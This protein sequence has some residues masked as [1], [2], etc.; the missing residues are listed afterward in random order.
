MR[1]LFF[2]LLT[3]AVTLSGTLARAGEPQ[4]K[5]TVSGEA[6]VKVSPDRVVVTLGIETM[7][8]NLEKAKSSNDRILQLAIKA[9]TSCCADLKEI[10][11]A[12]LSIAPR[13]RDSNRRTPEDFLGYFVNNAFAVTL[14]D[15]A[16][17]EQLLTV[18]LQA[19]VTNID[20]LSFETTEFKKYREQARE[21]ALQ[22]AREKAEKMAA[23]LGARV[24]APLQVTEGG[25]GWGYYSGWRGGAGGM[26]QNVMQSVGE[27]SDELYGS[28]A[29]GQISIRASVSVTFAL[30]N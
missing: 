19:G 24:G 2:F 25:A 27:A 21:L 13:Y 7:D 6:V 26:S 14:N 12:H 1:N 23:V 8:P 11:T 15:P 5:I 29:L 22:A 17:I 16:K 10:Q 28:V 30:T 9:I 4:P 3:L 18:A 20:N